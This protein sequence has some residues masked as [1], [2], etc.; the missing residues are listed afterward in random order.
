M[1][2]VAWFYWDQYLS[3]LDLRVEG[4]RLIEASG[5]VMRTIDSRLIG[6]I[7]AVTVQQ[8]ILD[9]VFGV[10]EVRFYSA[11]GSMKSMFIAFP[12]LTQRDALDLE[13]WF[14][15]Q[16]SRQC[17]PSEIALQKEAAGVQ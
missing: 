16:M 1:P 11:S 13:R 8:S 7:C 10:Y 3:T 2:F 4:F 14:S 5:L 15:D 6:I 17:S 9:K 12:D